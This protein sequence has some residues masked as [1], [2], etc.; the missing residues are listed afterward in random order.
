MN[1]PLALLFAVIGILLLSSI[2][3][4]I[5]L[6]LPWMVLLSSIAALLFIGYGF[7][8]KAKLRRKQ[9]DGS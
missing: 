4:F 2:S 1:K 3:F 5:S 6:G 8:L 9:N 7:G